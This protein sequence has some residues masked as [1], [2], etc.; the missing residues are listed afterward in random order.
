MITI[1]DFLLEKRMET[2]NQQINGV[3]LPATTKNVG[4][5]D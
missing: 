1:I 2:K 4:N 5:E 3:E